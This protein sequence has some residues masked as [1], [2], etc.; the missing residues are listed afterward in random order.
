MTRAAARNQMICSLALNLTKD[1]P[2]TELFG[3]QVQFFKSGDL[4]LYLAD[5][6]ECRT[7]NVHHRRHRKVAS[8]RVYADGTGEVVSIKTKPLDDWLPQVVHLAA[9]AMAQMKRPAPRLVVD[10][11]NP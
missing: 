4:T 2:V 1:Q 6:G 8:F 3:H 7:V 11:T 10:N 9:R 5:T